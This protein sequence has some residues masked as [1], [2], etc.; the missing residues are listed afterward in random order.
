MKDYPVYRAGSGAARFRSLR[1]LVLILVVCSLL[2]PPAGVEARAGQASTPPSWSAFPVADGSV[3]ESNFDGIGDTL[4]DGN[5][6]VLVG[7]N[8]FGP[9][10][11]RGV[12][13]FDIRSAAKITHGAR[14]IL[15]LNQV[16]TRFNGT[17]GHLTLY[18]G[19]GNGVLDPS[20][21]AAGS[22]VTDFE[23]MDLGSSL[24][25]YDDLIDVTK[26]V[27]HLMNQG[28]NYIVFVIRPNPIASNGMG[29][30]LFSSNEISSFY[31]FVPAKLVI[32]KGQ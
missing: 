5:N 2:M 10:E 23:A 13:E 12:Y 6:S 17:D 28:A 24:G 30:I 8:A 9:G 31:Q 15:Y 25:W 1:L 32:G 14:A 21:F 4:V 19:V 7:Y 29:A 20:D 26:V 3:I 16:G 11:E 22:Y 27:R 18:A